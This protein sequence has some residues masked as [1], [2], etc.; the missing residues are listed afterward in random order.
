MKKN[1]N[2][3]E[4][5][6]WDQGVR[7]VKKN[8][9]FM[10]VLLFFF[11]CDSQDRELKKLNNEKEKLQGE[12]LA[13][14]AQALEK[15]QEALAAFAEEKQQQLS[16]QWDRIQ[17]LYQ[18]RYAA[19]QLLIRFLDFHQ[20]E[21]TEQG[22]ESLAA[23]VYS[24]NLLEQESANGEIEPAAENEDF[25]E[26]QKMQDDLVLSLT[27]LNN[28]LTAIPQLNAMREYLE[29]QT[30][31]ERTSNRIAVERK[32]MDKQLKELRDIQAGN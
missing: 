22:K 21:L 9:L 3:H 16:A 13:K 17:G 5:R 2:L 25:A 26:F 6:H 14:Q 27:K 12:I 1:L 31:W 4:L 28:D 7:Q 19:L 10:T 18:E 8:I 29:F 24:L 32:E 30:T 20:D 15:Q 11:A 23:V